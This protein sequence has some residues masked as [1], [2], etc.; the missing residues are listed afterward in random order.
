[1]TELKT[2]LKTEVAAKLTKKNYKPVLMRL[3]A[4]LD[5]YWPHIQPLL[6]KCIEVSSEDETTSYHVYDH[7][8][9]G[10]AFLFVVLDEDKDVGD[11][12]V[13]VVVLQLVQYDLFAAF[14]IIGMAGKDLKQNLNKFWGH[15]KS[16]A[17]LNGVSTIEA[18]VRHPA[19]KNL[20]RDEGM[21][22]V[23]TRMRVDFTL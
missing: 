20:L 14:N 12:V 10:K 16:W 6:D 11:N 8:L 15:L 23:S 9:T 13:L 21:V 3:K 17:L 1:M 18:D 5:E 19:I 2:E 22:E 7:I 4:Q